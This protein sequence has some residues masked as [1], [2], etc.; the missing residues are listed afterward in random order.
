MTARETADIPMLTQVGYALGLLF[1]A[2]LGG[3]G[4]REQ[5]LNAVRF[6]TSNAGEFVLQNAG[7][8]LL[9]H[10]IDMLP[11]TERLTCPS[12]CG[13][14]ATATA[15]A[16]ANTLRVTAFTVRILRPIE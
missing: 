9:Q 14:K 4:A 5:H 10:G 8:F 6:V 12:V 3:A 1:F 11:L 15:S 2:P 7:Q 13:G 16:I